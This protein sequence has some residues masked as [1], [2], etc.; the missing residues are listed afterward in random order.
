MAIWGLI[1]GGGGIRDRGG[2]C[3]VAKA[4]KS[5]SDGGVGRVVYRVR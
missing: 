1:I 4:C 2:V 5:V 3:S